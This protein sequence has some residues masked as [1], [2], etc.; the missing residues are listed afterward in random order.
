[1]NIT[2]IF[3]SIKPY[4]RQSQGQL[5]LLAIVVMGGVLVITAV[6]SLYDSLNQISFRGRADQQVTTALNATSESTMSQLTKAP[7]FGASEQAAS[8]RINTT[9]HLMGVIVSA[10]QKQAE[11][12]IA[13]Q[14]KE[15]KV[16]RIN[17][18]LVDGGRL[19]SVYRD[20]VVLQR[21]GRLETLY[22]DWTKRGDKSTPVKRVPENNSVSE[23]LV[24]D[25]EDDS[26]ATNTTPTVDQTSVQTPEAWQ[27]RI[28]EIREKYQKQ[29]GAQGE[30]GGTPST[31]T[32][33]P[34]A[35]PIRGFKGRLGG[36]NDE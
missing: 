32:P 10:N 4:Y 34:F 19:R 1:M 3:T 24:T 33:T 8:Q 14:G 36:M 5:W 18:E 26:A 23:N 17:D 6:Y 16:Y 28:K 2:D 12:I 9:L 27:E 15:A 31:P 35:P 11:A 30:A 29:F 25:I 7:L 20:R 13:S 21:D 22:L